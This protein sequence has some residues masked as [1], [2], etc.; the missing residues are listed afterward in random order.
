MR[1]FDGQRVKEADDV[2]VCAASEQQQAVL[3][4]NPFDFVGKIGVRLFSV[5]EF[6][7]HHRAQAAHFAYFGRVQVGQEGFQLAAQGLRARQQVFFRN[8]VQHRQTCGNAQ[9]VACVCAAQSARARRV[10]N[11]RPAGHAAQ[12]DAARQRFGHG[13]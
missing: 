9:R 4:G 7:R 2:A 3:H 8:N 5:A 11:L 6:H 1:L 10:H 12:H 13:D